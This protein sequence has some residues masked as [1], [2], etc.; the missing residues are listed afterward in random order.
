[1]F[2]V[3]DSDCQMCYN[4]AS[5]IQI[6]KGDSQCLTLY[7]RSVRFHERAWSD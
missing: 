3:V 1:M 4:C 6:S 7:M 2:N 5:Q